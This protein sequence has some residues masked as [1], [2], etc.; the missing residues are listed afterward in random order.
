MNG[1]MN[2]QQ[3]ATKYI[4]KSGHRIEHS[5][6]FTIDEVFDETKAYVHFEFHTRGTKTV[7]SYAI[8]VSLL[9]RGQINIA[10]SLI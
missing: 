6:A 2:Y 1:D 5:T 10:L 4:L 7:S 3:A 9:Q 8:S